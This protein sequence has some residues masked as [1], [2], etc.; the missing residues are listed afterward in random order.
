[1][2]ILVP[3]RNSWFVHLENLIRSKSKQIC[4]VLLCMCLVV[5]GASSF[6]SSNPKASPFKTIPDMLQMDVNAISAITIVRM[7][8]GVRAVVRDQVQIYRILDRLG[9]VQVGKDLGSNGYTLT[10]FHLTFDIEDSSGSRTVSIQLDS[11]PFAYHA[12]YNG[13]FFEISDA[14]TR[15]KL[16]DYFNQQNYLQTAP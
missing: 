6:V 10:G 5:V 13:R 2:Q 7:G 12:A 16:N 15:N 1:M 4:I 3:V 9:Q 8:D 14:D 11:S